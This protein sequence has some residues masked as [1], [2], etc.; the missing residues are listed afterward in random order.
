MLDFKYFAGFI[1]ADGSLG[2]HVNK[3]ADGSFII[4]P[5][6][7]LGQVQREVDNLKEFADYYDVEVRYRDVNSLYVVELTGTK[8]Q[9]CLESVKKHLV[10]K[11]ELA[12]YILSLPARAT[13]EE[14]KAYR[15]VIKNLRKKNTPSKNF[16]SRKWM[17]GYVDGDGCFYSRCDKK[18]T[19]QT[20]LIIAS[21]A[22]ALAGLNLIKK[23]FGGCILVRGNQSKYELFLSQTKLNEIFDYIGKHLRIKKTQMVLLKDYVG[24]GKCSKY[25]GATYEQNKAFSELLAT[26]KYIGRESACYSLTE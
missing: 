23:A 5:K 25:N 2:I 21:S 13:E 10:I 12:E 18:G 17:A 4:Y 15:I 6:V 24:S 16:P 8:A 11:D 3:A 14:L 22:D 9:R 20:K 7:H 1:D 26:T 19:L